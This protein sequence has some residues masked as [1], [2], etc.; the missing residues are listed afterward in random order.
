MV[1]IWIS[2]ILTDQE[3]SITLAS[4]ASGY[5]NVYSLFLVMMIFGYQSWLNA[6]Q[7]QTLEQDQK[8][9]SARL[10]IEKERLAEAT[11][12]LSMIIHEVKNPLNYIRLASNNLSH[13]LQYSQE[14]LTRLNH[15]KTSVTAIDNVLERS[16]QVDTLEHGAM[17]IDKQ[18]HEVTG[19]LDDFI[20]L[21]SE[22]NRVVLNQP[23][24]LWANIDA[25]LI[26]MMLRNLI[27]NALKYSP[28]DTPVQLCV[29]NEDQGLSLKVSNQVSHA[30]YPDPAQLFRKYYRSTQAMNIS[31]TGLG[32][33]WVQ[34]VAK[35]MGG[36]VRYKPQLQLNLVCF[37]LW[38]PC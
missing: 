8:I 28:A 11:S 29:S 2:S 36:E 19:L 20:M 35:Q 12:F 13:D 5:F 32:L 1:L 25:N 21:T 6:Q 3:I 15:I 27:D 9:I 38:I 7:R 33:Y 26:L 23:E 30:G 34:Q 22:H 37:E 31:G 14:S 4:W 17:N 18:N 24:S 16:L 10:Q